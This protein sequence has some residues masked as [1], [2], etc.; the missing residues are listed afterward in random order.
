MVLVKDMNEVMGREDCERFPKQVRLGLD[1][2][3]PPPNP[4]GTG[5]LNL[6]I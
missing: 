4:Q 6:P 5:A 1:R 2:E 3:V